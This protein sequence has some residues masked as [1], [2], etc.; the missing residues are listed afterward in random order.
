MAKTAAYVQ[1][2]EALDYKNGSEEMIPAWT[3]VLIGNRIGVAGCDIPAGAVGTVHVT[4][5]FEI[6]KKASVELRAGDDVTFTDA[7]GID[8]ATSDAVGY[9][10][11]DAAEAAATAKV[12]LL[13]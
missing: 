2:G 11:E 13:V 6:P 7:D 4:G 10:V 12:K 1:R 3:V 9:A 8:K 5:V